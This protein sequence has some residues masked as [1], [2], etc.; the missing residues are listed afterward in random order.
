MKRII[1]RHYTKFNKYLIRLKFTG[2]EK[3]SMTICRFHFS[4][5]TKESII[6][7]VG[8]YTNHI[9]I[10]F[11]DS[12]YTHGASR[13]KQYKTTTSCLRRSSNL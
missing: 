13:D 7:S 10:N 9:F 11:N 5:K 2:L 3:I 6:F 8:R 4:E 12:K 1:L